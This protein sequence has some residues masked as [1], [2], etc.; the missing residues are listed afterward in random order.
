MGIGSRSFWNIELNRWNPRKDQDTPHELPQVKGP[1]LLFMDHDGRFWDLDGGD[2]PPNEREGVH[3]R[4]HAN[5]SATHPRR[6][7]LTWAALTVLETA[8]RQIMS[9]TYRSG[10]LPYSPRRLRQMV[11]TFPPGGRPRNWRIIANNGKKQ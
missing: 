11:V 1:V 3:Q 10:H 4:P 8:Y 9:D 2:V 5:G 7:S 6:D